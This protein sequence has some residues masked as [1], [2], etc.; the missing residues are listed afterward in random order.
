M[1]LFFLMAVAF[2]S[3]FSVFALADVPAPAVV[4]PNFHAVSTGVYRGGAPGDG[5]IAYLQSLQIKSDL[6][7]EGTRF[8]AILPEKQ[9][10]DA[11]GI[12]YYSYPLLSLPGILGDVQ[13][14]L[15]DTEMNTILALIASPA[16]QPIYV[17]C[18]KGDDRTGLVIGLHRVVNEQWT[19]ADAW[20]EMLE[21]GYHPHFV[22]LT[23]YFEQRTGWTP[24]Q[25]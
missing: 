4:P 12:Q 16:A 23:R 19:P 14:D 3:C 18:E 24:P 6:D 25:N 10:A 9:D 15:N 5:G 7:L 21:Y 1:R 22:A 20:A 17:H 13:P 2:S 8:W 11:V